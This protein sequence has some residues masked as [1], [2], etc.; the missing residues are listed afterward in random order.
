ML[1]A[2]FFRSI[3][4]YAIEIV[5]LDPNRIILVLFFYAALVLE[6]ATV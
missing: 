3:F 5:F 6:F 1:E 2:S 4:Q